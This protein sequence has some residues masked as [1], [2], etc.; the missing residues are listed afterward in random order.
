LPDRG[1]LMCGLSHL[2]GWNGE[3][4]KNHLPR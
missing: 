1:G 4:W 2:K 3:S